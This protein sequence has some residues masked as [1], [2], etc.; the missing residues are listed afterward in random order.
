MFTRQ[1]YSFAININ[2]ETKPIA[3]PIY[4][5]KKIEQ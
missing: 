5:L 1:N 4:I 3:N 2:N